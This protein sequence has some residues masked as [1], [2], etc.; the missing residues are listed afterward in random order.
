MNVGIVLLVLFVAAIDGDIVVVPSHSRELQGDCSDEL[1]GA[2]TCIEFQTYNFN[3]Y[4]GACASC[5]DELVSSAPC[6]D[7]ILEVCEEVDA[8]L[9]NA[10]A[11]KLFTDQYLICKRGL[12]CAASTCSIDG[13]EDTAP[14]PSTVAT[15]VPTAAAC[16]LPSSPSAE[17]TLNFQAESAQN[18]NSTEACCSVTQPDTAFL[19]GTIVLEFD[20]ALGRTN[21]AYF[22]DGD[23]L[24]FGPINFGS[25][26]CAVVVLYY[27][28]GDLVATYDPT[29]EEWVNY[30][31]KPTAM[32]EF[33]L[34]GEQGTL[35]GT[36]YPSFTGGWTVYTTGVATVQATDTHSLYL[37]AT[38]DVGILNLDY[39]EIT[40]EDNSDVA[41]PPPVTSLPSV[42]SITTSPAPSGPAVG[43]TMLP[44]AIPTVPATPVV[45]GE[46]PRDDE[47]GIPPFTSS[48]VASSSHVLV[49]HSSML[50][51]LV[52]VYVHDVLQIY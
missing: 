30:E 44:T 11:C 16:N 26:G 8:C 3:S 10:A 24:R 49:S 46:Q 39:I 7:V 15:P 36:F 38:G 22:D 6:T 51:A 20:T 40:I 48:P 23:Y 13:A 4:A 31:P 45:V 42:P 50:I 32:L 14:P 43:S 27:S 47:S 41:A 9:C 12:N 17:T 37:V 2:Q 19:A 29:T 35:V 21:I 18:I 33:R 34:D 25:G 5:V 28:K 52:W 1:S